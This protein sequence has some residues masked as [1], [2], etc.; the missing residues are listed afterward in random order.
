MLWQIAGWINGPFRT[1]WVSSGWFGELA[2]RQ[3]QGSGG[4][5]FAE[6]WVFR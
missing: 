3:R 5:F 6:R 4:A 1:G 2:V